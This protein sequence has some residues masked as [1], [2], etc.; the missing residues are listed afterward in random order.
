MSFYDKESFMEAAGSLRFN[1]PPSD[2]S[3]TPQQVGPQE[4]SEEICFNNTR[5]NPNTLEQ[6]EQARIR[7]E[8]PD[9]DEPIETA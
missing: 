9:G 8:M 5:N 3:N 7:F 6:G 4:R 1:N 2:H